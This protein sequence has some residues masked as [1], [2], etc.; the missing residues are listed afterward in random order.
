MATSENYL[1]SIKCWL[2]L[3]SHLKEGD[4][5]K[6]KR[7][8]CQHLA[9]L[10][11]N[12]TCQAPVAGLRLQPPRLS[13]LARAGAR[14]L[15]RGKGWL[16][17]LNHKVKLGNYAYAKRGRETARSNSDLPPPPLKAVTFIPTEGLWAFLSVMTGNLGK[18]PELSHPLF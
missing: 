3:H 6:D 13:V 11:R 7:A 4:R 15:N 10:P 16:A 14:Y 9:W 8:Q 2:K 17:L 5:I 12:A 18:F 1:T